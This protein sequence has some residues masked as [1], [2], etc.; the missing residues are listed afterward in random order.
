MRFTTLDLFNERHNSDLLKILSNTK[1][2]QIIYN[3]T[4]I[5]SELFSGHLLAHLKL[6]DQLKKIPNA[7]FNPTKF[8]DKLSQING[9]ISY[10]EAIRLVD[11]TT[12]I[13]Y[14]IEKILCKIYV[15]NSITQ[16][17]SV[18]NFSINYDYL[19]TEAL[20][21][22]A[23]N[24]AIFEYVV[25]N[26]YVN[27][28]LFNYCELS[29]KFMPYD[30]LDVL[31][32]HGFDIA[33]YPIDSSCVYAILSYISLPNI[34]YFSNVKINVSQYVTIVKQMRYEKLKEFVRHYN[35]ENIIHD[36]EKF[37]A[38]S[39]RAQILIHSGINL[40]TLLNV[41]MRRHGEHDHFI[42]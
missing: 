8:F 34:K 22:N 12:E 21:N 23:N 5:H 36:N 17:I 2:V 24:R 27:C 40:E 4:T 26:N 25:S 28:N 11:V 39:D 13:N 29:K 19:F 41:I 18:A 10:S 37:D 35:T 30:F 15:A 20:R 3:T 38:Q 6:F 16:I 14:C 9:N 33:N 7:N 31:L 1:D 42:I 32:T